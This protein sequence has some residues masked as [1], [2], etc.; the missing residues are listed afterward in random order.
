[1]ACNNSLNQARIPKWGYHPP[2]R[3]PN[4]SSGLVCL[5]YFGGPNAEPQQVALDVKGLLWVVLV[6]GERSG[7]F[8]KGLPPK[9]VFVCVFWAMEIL[10]C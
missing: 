10:P 5:V 3:H 9:N 8:N 4:T 1:M 6:S 2:S 7:N